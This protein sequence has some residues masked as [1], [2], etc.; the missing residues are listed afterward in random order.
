MKS[1]KLEYINW[2]LFISLIVIIVIGGKFM[3]GAS[4]RI[5]KEPAASAQP[6]V[7][8]HTGAMREP[9]YEIEKLRTANVKP[10]N[11]DEVYKAFPKEAA[12][13]NMIA[14]WDKVNP[15]DKKKFSDTIDKEIKTAKERLAANPG[16]REA[17]AKLFISDTLK[18]LAANGFNYNSQVKAQEKR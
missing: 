11:M 18:K 16:D 5:Q 2:I 13:D 4:P 8:P 14:T 15:E 12:G 10:R 7:K 6:E 9:I 3:K 1:K 17:K